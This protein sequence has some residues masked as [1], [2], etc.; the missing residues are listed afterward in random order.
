MVLTLQ[1]RKWTNTYCELRCNTNRFNQKS[2]N[3]VGN[4]T[5][6]V[7]GDVTGNVRGSAGSCTGNSRRASTV[8]IDL[9]NSATTLLCN[10]YYRNTSN[11]ELKVD[12]NGAGLNHA[13]VSTNTLT[14]GVFSGTATQAQYADLAEIYKSR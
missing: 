5:G 1:H 14:P 8:D 6:D 11:G 13:P 3:F 2:T 10:I 9:D 7:A 12:N 4:S